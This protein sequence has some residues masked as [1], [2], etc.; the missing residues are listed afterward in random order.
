M[1]FDIKFYVANLIK[2]IVPVEETFPE[3]DHAFPVAIIEV[4]NDTANAFFDG[5]EWLT[6]FSFTVSILTK[7]TSGQP[8]FLLADKVNTALQTAGFT[9][10]SAREMNYTDVQ[11]RTLTYSATICPQ[12]DRIYRG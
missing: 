5:V 9:R 12:R 4:T 7:E 6:D 3:I 10:V 11:R 1:G 8:C 2:D